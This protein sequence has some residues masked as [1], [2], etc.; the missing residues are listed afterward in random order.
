MEDGGAG[1]PRLWPAVVR[2]PNSDE[3]IT[4]TKLRSKRVY[5]FLGLLYCF[6]VLSPG[7]TYC[8]LYYGTI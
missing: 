4:S 2:K 3:G 5:D 1:L 6:I 7:C 8:I